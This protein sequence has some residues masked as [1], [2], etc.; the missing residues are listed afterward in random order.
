M[1]FRFHISFI[2]LL[3]L[4]QAKA[5]LPALPSDSTRLTLQGVIDTDSLLEE[6]D[7]NT[8]LRT[9]PLTTLPKAPLLLIKPKKEIQSVDLS[10]E[11]QAFDSLINEKTIESKK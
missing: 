2:F 5:M 11:K 6:I 8:K 4:L 1:K 7:M 10:T 3:C 9:K